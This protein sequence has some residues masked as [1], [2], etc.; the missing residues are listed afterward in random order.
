MKKSDASTMW[1][2]MNRFTHY[3]D[4]IDLNEKFLPELAKV[5]E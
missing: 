2:Y 4:L 3:D 5:E 1:N